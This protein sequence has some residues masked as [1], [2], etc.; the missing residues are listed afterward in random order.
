MLH[1]DFK[2]VC[3]LGILLRVVEGPFIAPMPLNSCWKQA[4]ESDLRW[5]HW[6]GPVR[7]RTG[8][9]SPQSEILIGTFHS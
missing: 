5:W 6:T 7:H 9:L 8:F 3:C 1:N 2:L 4:M